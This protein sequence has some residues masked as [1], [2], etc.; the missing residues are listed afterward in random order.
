VPQHRRITTLI[1]EITRII[2]LNVCRGLFHD[3]KL[4][5]ALTLAVRIA[6]NSKALTHQEWDFFTKGLILSAQQSLKKPDNL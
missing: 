4:I 1:K 6:L 2:Y 5:F 3:D